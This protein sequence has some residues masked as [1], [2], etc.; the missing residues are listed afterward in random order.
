MKP[1]RL[2]AT[3]VVLARSAPHKQYMHRHQ[4]INTSNDFEVLMMKRH[5]NARFVPNSYVFPGGGIDQEDHTLFASCDTG[6]D[7][8][9]KAGRVAALRELAEETGSV[10]R[11]DGTL[12]SLAESAPY[13]FCNGVDPS[14]THRLVKMGRWVTPEGFPLRNDTL[15]FG[16]IAH[17]EERAVQET[18]LTQ[19]HSE[20]EN[21]VWISPSEAL[22]LHED[23][24]NDFNLPTP[25]FFLLLALAKE[26]H[27][28]TIEAHWARQLSA[29]EEPPV[30]TVTQKVQQ[31][32][33][34]TVEFTMPNNYFCSLPSSALLPDGAYRFISDSNPRGVQHSNIYIG[35][36]SDHVKDINC[37]SFCNA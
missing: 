37:S 24:R 28:A 19:Q 34:G 26:P 8:L 22:R 12:L 1:V 20:V 9:D 35:E 21:L 27:L 32:E 2:A 10:L 23:P 14:A 30:T 11:G 18:R 13:N 25:T 29:K 5:R 7:T 3:L 36:A 17:H 16:C 6:K 4:Q 15:F 31:G 33:N